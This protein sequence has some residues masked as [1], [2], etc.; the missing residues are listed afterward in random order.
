MSMHRYLVMGAFA[1]IACPAFAGESTG[2]AASTDSQDVRHRELEKMLRDAPDVEKFDDVALGEIPPQGLDTPILTLHYLEGSESALKNGQMPEATTFVS[3][4]GLSAVS[5]GKPY[6]V[7]IVFKP[8]G[9]GRRAHAIIS[10]GAGLPTVG[11]TS[12]EF[13][14]ADGTSLQKWTYA[15]N[16]T[17][18]VLLD[19]HEVI[20]AAYVVIHAGGNVHLDNIGVIRPL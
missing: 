17:F 2:S 15:T 4:P 8:Q 16:T 1:L 12:V 7:K 19:Y 5:A 13:F 20:P 3:F 14:A 6:A 18:G 9:I 10:L 11:E